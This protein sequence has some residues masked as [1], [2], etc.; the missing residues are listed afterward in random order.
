MCFDP[1]SAAALAMGVEAATVANTVG[2][3]GAATSAVGTYATMQGQAQTAEMNAKIAKEN[4]AK[5]VQTG[6]LEADRVRDRYRALVADQTVAAVKGGVNPAAGS[7]ALLINQETE[8]NAF[9]D[10]ATTIWNRETEAV[11]GQNRARALKSEA[12]TIAGVAPFAAGGSFLTGMGNAA[13][14]VR[15]S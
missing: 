8:R 10:I 1:L 11:A 15:L 7:P 9:L 13:R 6:Q 3:I 5:A 4:A 2:V 14:G 12:E